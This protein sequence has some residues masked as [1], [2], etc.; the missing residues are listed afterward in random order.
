MAPAA[1]Q[2]GGEGKEGGREG[3]RK[4]LEVGREEEEVE[5]EEE[6]EA[7]LRMDGREEAREGGVGGVGAR[8]SASSTREVSEP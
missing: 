4:E 2:A 8:Q 1:R 6:D 7:V 5:E 3:G